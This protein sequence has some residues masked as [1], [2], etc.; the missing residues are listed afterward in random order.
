MVAAFFEQSLV[1]SPL[2]GRP[3]VVTLF[4]TTALRDTISYQEYS[5]VAAFFEENLVYSP[6][7]VTL[8]LAI[9]T[10]W[11]DISLNLSSYFPI[12]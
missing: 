9:S 4:Y 8:Y 10:D 5:L 2:E 3:S 6:S 1:Y 11:L 12:L 7:V